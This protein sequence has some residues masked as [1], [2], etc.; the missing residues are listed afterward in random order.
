[1]G[2]TQPCINASKNLY[3]ELKSCQKLKDIIIF[4]EHMGHFC[5]QIEFK[6]PIINNI[7]S[8]MSIGYLPDAYGNHNTENPEIIET[9]LIDKNGKKCY[10]DFL[11]YSDICIFDSIEDLIQEI[12]RL[13]QYSIN[14]DAPRILLT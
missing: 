12:I 13:S 9:V 2:N 10:V 3:T 8:G 11:G 14:Y 1:M 6:K 4:K 7:F 5:F